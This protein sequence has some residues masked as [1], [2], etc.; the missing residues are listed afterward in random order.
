MYFISALEESNF[1]E[2]KCFEIGI[3]LVEMSLL[4]KKLYW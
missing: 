3:F 2:M 4:A 1:G